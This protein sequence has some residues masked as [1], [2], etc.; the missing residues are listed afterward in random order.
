MKASELAALLLKD[1]DN[2]VI[3]VTQEAQGLPWKTLVDH[4]PILLAS[5]VGQ[6]Y[7]GVTDYVVAVARNRDRKV[8]GT[9]PRR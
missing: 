4:Q 7:L 6:T 1:P 8:I 3:I 2:E 9:A 5:P